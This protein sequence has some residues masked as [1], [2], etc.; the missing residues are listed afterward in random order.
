MNTFMCAIFG[1]PL[2]PDYLHGKDFGLLP[3]LTSLAMTSGVTLCCWHVVSFWTCPRT[4]HPSSSS[5]FAQAVAS[6]GSRM[7]G[8]TN[9]CS[10]QNESFCKLQ[11]LLL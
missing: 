6:P 1:K 5:S 9:Y 4:E 7:W 3:V 11:Q 10:D 2:M 8:G